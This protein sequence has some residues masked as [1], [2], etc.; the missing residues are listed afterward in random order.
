MTG[1]NPA[2][3]TAAVLLFGLAGFFLWRHFSE[4]DGISNHAFFYDLSEKKLFTA[5]RSLVPPIQGI[6]GNEMDGVGAVVISLSGDPDDKAS[7]KIAYLERY[8]P[9]LKQ[10]LEE[11]Q[12]TGK[13]ARIG[14]TMAQSLRFVRR[15]NETNWY[16]LE[17]D[18]GNRIVS[19]WAAPG[20]NG[21]NPVVCTP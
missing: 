4:G 20:P 7:R 8:S 1:S 21:V 16:S 15:E 11:A 19:E 10:D 9:E 18:E 12:R 3:I 14:R 2:K 13:A 6:N 5:A 17:S